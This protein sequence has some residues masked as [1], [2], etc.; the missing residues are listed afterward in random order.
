MNTQQ[1]SALSSALYGLV[2]ASVKTEM[3]EQRAR[4]EQGTVDVQWS[5]QLR[6]AELRLQHVLLDI[7]IGAARFELSDTSFCN[8]A[9]STWRRHL[10]TDED[11]NGCEAVDWL[12]DWLNRLQASRSATKGTTTP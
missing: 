9:L 10:E 3:E 4:L 8:E 11:I 2:F 7:E 1:A 5:Q 6:R 12:V